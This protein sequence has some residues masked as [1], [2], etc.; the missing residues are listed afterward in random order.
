MIDPVIRDL[1]RYLADVEKH[2]Y[3]VMRAE[4]LVE[5]DPERYEGLSDDELYDLAY[6]QLKDDAEAAEELRAERMYE[7]RLFKWEH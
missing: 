3:I 4:Q 1:N 5:E 7:E 6:E 2:D